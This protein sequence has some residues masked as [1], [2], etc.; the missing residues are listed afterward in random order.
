MKAKTLHLISESIFKKKTYKP[1]KTNYILRHLLSSKE[2]I[3]F[4]AQVVLADGRQATVTE[5][6]VSIYRGRG[7]KPRTIR[8][9]EVDTEIPI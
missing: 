2:I 4:I 3:V 7:R 6:G 9:S 8:M 5:D 1:Q